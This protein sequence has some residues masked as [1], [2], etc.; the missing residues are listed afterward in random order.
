MDDER[1]DDPDHPMEDWEDPDEDDEEEVDEAETRECPMCGMEI[2]EDAV[3]CPLCGEYVGRPSTNALAGWP[4]WFV[5]LGVLGIAGVIYVFL[6]I[7]GP[8]Q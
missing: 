6:T 2:Y 1:F 3:R 8:A 7:L 5:A 4:W